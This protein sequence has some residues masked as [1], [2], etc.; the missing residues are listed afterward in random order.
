MI[1]KFNLEKALK[2][3]DND[4]DLL[5]EIIQLFKSEKITMLEEIN[6]ALNSGNLDIIKRS[7]HSIKGTLAN[8]G[9]DLCVD[10]AFKIETTSS[11][12]N[13]PASKD[14]FEKLKIDI[15]EYLVEVK[16]KLSSVNK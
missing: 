6:Q 3:T 5:Q 1:H 13:I 15:E 16:E 11:L 9:A 8:I 7:A 14:L 2:I 12:E 10:S 4:Y